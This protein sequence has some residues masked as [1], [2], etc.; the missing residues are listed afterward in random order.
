MAEAT[1]AELLAWAGTVEAATKSKMFPVTSQREGEKSLP[2]VE[3]DFKY[4]KS[5]ASTVA[6]DDIGARDRTLNL[7]F[8]VT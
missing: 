4:I 7:Y 3:V 8:K 2:I 5:N 6:G 1:T